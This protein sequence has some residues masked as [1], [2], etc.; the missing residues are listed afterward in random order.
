MDGPAAASQGARHLRAHRA[1]RRQARVPR[2]HAALRRV[3]APGGAALSRARTCWRACSIASRRAAAAHDPLDDRRD[4]PRGRAR[5]AHAAADRHHAKPLLRVRR[6]AAHRL[7]DRRAGAR[8][9]PRHRDQRLAPRRP[10]D[11]RRRRRQ[12]Y[13][14]RIHWSREA[15]PLETAGGIATAMPLLPDGP[16]II[17]SGDIWT[18]SITGAA[19]G[20]RRDGAGSR[21]SHACTS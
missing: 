10:H 13:G 1:S 7:A 19:A 8:R 2:G 16:A 21:A 17:V 4:D 6:Q 3:R 15:E 12:R 18:T 14:V 11:R 20:R 9:R 5:R